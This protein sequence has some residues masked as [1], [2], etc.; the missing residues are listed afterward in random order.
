MLDRILCISC[1]LVGISAVAQ[2]PQEDAPGARGGLAVQELFG[3][4]E[5]ILERVEEARVPEQ[6]A[7]SSPDQANARI[8]TADQCVAIALRENPQVLVSDADVSRV[9]EQ[10]GQAQARM[11]PQLSASLGFNYDPNADDS[12]GGSNFL[13][14]IIFDAD[15]E[16]KEITRQE[17]VAVEQVLYTGGQIRAAV[18]AARH[19]AQSQEWQRQ[20]TL[21]E[22]AFQTREAYYNA[23]LATALV[24]VA[25][26]S[27]ITFQ[28]HLDDTQNMAEA[29]M[30]GGFEVLRART[31]LGAREADLITAKNAERIA[32]TNLRR[33]LG[34]PQNE[35]ILLHDDLEWRPYNMNRERLIAEALENRPEL[36]ALDKSIR[37]AEQDLRRVKGEYVPRL[38]AR[39]EWT[40]IDGGGAVTPDGFTANIGA[41]WPIYVGGRRKHARAE[42]KYQIRSL[43]HQRTDLERLIEFDV[44]QARIRVEDAIAKIRREKGNIELAAEGE[45][46]AALRFQTGVSTQAELLDAELALTNAESALVQALRDYAVA[47]AALDKALGKG[48]VDYESAERE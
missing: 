6:V 17:R 48:A 20:V 25:D 1:F 44:R 47:I 18:K 4:A 11:F 46:L 22:I 13:T 9:K 2:Q 40:N 21:E 12:F 5:E 28:R 38:G 26:R 27:V 32:Y 33:T 36:Q 35:A 31:E 15:I 34:I 41:E 23:L 19:L 7:P 43:E 39:A 16:R 8:L 24:R 3:G 10:I 42:A 45:R 30:V 14:D 37:A 29:G